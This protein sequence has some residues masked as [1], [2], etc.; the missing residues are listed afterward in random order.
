MST[1]RSKTKASTSY[2]NFNIVLEEVATGIWKA[3]KE[4]RGNCVSFTPKK[5]LEYAGVTEDV[6][7]IMLTLVRYIL[8]EL[9]KKDLLQRDEKRYR[10]CRYNIYED[11]SMSENPLWELCKSSDTPDSVIKLLRSLVE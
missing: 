5:V 4:A 3:V 10:I 9:V 1:S 7:P 11:G 2:S 8:D 6:K